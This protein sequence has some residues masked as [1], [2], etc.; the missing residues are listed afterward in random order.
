MLLVFYSSG[1]VPERSNG[2]AWK[3]CVPQKGTEGSNPSLSA[4]AD[5]V[6]IICF[7]FDFLSRRIKSDKYAILIPYFSFVPMFIPLILLLFG[8][9]PVSEDEIQSNQ[10]ILIE[11]ISKEISNSI[12]TSDLRILISIDPSNPLAVSELTHYLL[13]SGFNITSTDGESIHRLSIHGTT[14]NTLIQNGVNRYQR[15]LHMDGFITLLDESGTVLISHRFSIYHTDL[16][17]LPDPQI[18]EGA[19]QLSRFTVKKQS[20]LRGLINKI[21]QPVLIASAIGTTIYLLYNVRS[22]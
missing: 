18:L 6:R 19:W 5:N 21:G 22:Q 20:G 3:A 15:I 1:E 11:G 16:I 4:K 2:L 8:G 12:Q 10:S 13:N 17:K 7:F 9:N 14:E